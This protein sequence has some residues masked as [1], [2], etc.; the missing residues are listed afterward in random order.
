[1]SSQRDQIRAFQ[2]LSHLQFSQN[3]VKYA[4]TL[5]RNLLLK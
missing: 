1:V 2:L 3:L 4:H 5:S